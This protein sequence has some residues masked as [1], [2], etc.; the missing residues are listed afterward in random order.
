MNIEKEVADNLKK[1]GLHK[2]KPTLVG[3]SGGADSLALLQIMYHLGYHVTAVYVDHGLRDTSGKDGDHVA[4]FCRKQQIPFRREKID[5]LAYAKAAKKTVEEASRELRYACLFEIA[6][7]IDAGAVAVAHHADDQVETVL[8]HLLRGAGMSGLRGMQLIT[9]RHEWK[10]DIP[11]IRPL[12]TIWK[13]EIQRY[14]ESSNIEAVIDE[15]NFDTTY[16]RNRLRHELIPDLQTYSPGVKQHL[17]TMSTLL[18]DDYAALE[19]MVHDALL[20]V[21]IIF[22]DMQVVFKRAPFLTYSRAIQR[23]MLRKA[24][25]GLCPA[26]RDVNAIA[27]ERCI[28]FLQRGNPTGQVDVTDHL[29]L[30]VDAPHVVIKD[31][32]TAYFREDLPLL[33]DGDRHEFSPGSVLPINPVWGFRADL[34]P[35]SDYQIVDRRQ[36]PWI[37]ALDAERCNQPLFMQSVRQGDWFL[38]EGLQGHV[39]KLS[40]ILINQKISRYLR[41]RFPLIRN[42][43]EVI[44]V[45]GYR[46]HEHMQVTVQTKQVLLLRFFKLKDN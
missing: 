35:V 9:N 21:E 1:T 20:R 27:I 29:V 24:I 5:A 39:Q 42:E 7:E 16:F 13:E 41:D 38:P 36:Q 33:G 31:G 8:M 26:L 32:K 46:V 11:L 37:A 3:V 10:S 17:L 34:I 18:Q 45:P 23:M 40:D 30:F 44:W 25:D 12:I 43:Q 6:G 22:S 14:C 19:E 4:A 15:S 28:D 2:V